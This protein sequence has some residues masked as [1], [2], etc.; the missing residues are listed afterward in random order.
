MKIITNSKGQFF[1]TQMWSEIKK[2][3]GYPKND[4]N[5]GFIYG[6]HPI[7]HDGQIIEC[8]WFKTENDRN[9]F[10]EGEKLS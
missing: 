8:F 7:D 9:K 4:D 5:N 6:C 2:D 3:C 10:Y 1:E